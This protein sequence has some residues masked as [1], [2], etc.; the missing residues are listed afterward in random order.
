[1]RQARELDHVRRFVRAG[2]RAHQDPLVLAD[3]SE[4]DLSVACTIVGGLNGAGK[5]RL[6]KSIAGQLS[7]AAV[8]IDLHRL[9]EQVL[10]LIAQRPD[11]AAISEEFSPMELAGERLDDISRIIGRDY[12]TVEWYSLEIEPGDE[13]AAEQF[14][15]GGQQSLVP[16]FKVSTHGREYDS[17][18][19]GLGELSVHLL[20]WVLEQ[21]RDS[22][23]L[24]LLLDEPDA[25][26]PP[27]GVFGLLGRLSA[28][29]LQRKWNLI[30]TTHSDELIRAAMEHQVFTYLHVNDAGETS[31]VH[32]IADPTAAETLLPRPAVDMVVVCEDES[33][34]YLAQALIDVVDPV[35]RSR[36]TF[37]W[38][39]GHAALT[40]VDQNLR[41]PPGR[42]SIRFV[43]AYDGDMRDR[44]P[45]PGYWARIFLPTDRSPDELLRELSGDAGALA[46]A[47]GV[48]QE[49]LARV[50]R[51]LAGRDAHDWVNEICE[52]VGRQVGLSRMG[53]LWVAAHPQEA[54]AFVASMTATV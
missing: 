19:M 10:G 54:A 33:A 40:A 53:R 4:I 11:V 9:C 29:C 15:W 17:T 43:F 14:S 7:D 48:D 51:S 22:E 26:L 36:A 8:L 38:G 21:Y 30:L 32:S 18:E 20:F 46:S 39:G 28:F 25:F 45:V 52:L 2:D 34:S 42:P 50:L 12:E 23:N 16:Y 1:M 3:G 24:T 13:R 35:L 5:S 47:L 27:V 41:K 44:A 31:A 49:R 37:I 6:L